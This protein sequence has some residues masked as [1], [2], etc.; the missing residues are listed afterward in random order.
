VLLAVVVLAPGYL[1][2][3][4]PRGHDDAVP[5]C[6]RGSSCGASCS[7]HAN[8]CDGR[9]CGVSEHAQASKHPG[10][11]CGACGTHTPAATAVAA[12]DYLVARPLRVPAPSAIARVTPF[13]A[14]RAFPA[15]EEPQAP[16]PRA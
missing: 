12:D 4:T 14:P 13:A 6:C 3:V 10:F 8:R 11:H 16:P 7:M 1:G 5:V 9:S 15:A 2:L